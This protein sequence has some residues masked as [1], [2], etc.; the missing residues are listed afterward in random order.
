MDITNKNIE[1][2]E[3]LY[4][5]VVDIWNRLCECNQKLYQLTCKEYSLL[6]KSDL[7]KL[8]LIL[9]EKNNIIN[10]VSKL[11]SLR[12]EVISEIQPLVPKTEINNV[13]KLIAFLEM[14]EKSKKI[15]HIGKFNSLLIDTIQ[16]I[17]NQN[18]LNQ[19]FINKAILSLRELKKDTEGI[20]QDYTTYSSSGAP[21][22]RSL[23]K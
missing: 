20:K 13:S 9:S 15:N 22:T 11:D 12:S 21:K 3:V 19:L 5:Q 4:F 1:K 14:F 17:K 6:L 2:L 7:E 16:K 10:Q 8:D 18:K 23:I